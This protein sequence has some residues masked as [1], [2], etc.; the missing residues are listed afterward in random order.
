MIWCSKFNTLP[1]RKHCGSCFDRTL[2]KP[3]AHLGSRGGAK[4]EAK[5]G[6]QTRMGVF[7]HPFVCRATVW[8]RHRLRM[9]TNQISQWGIDQFYF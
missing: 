1:H 9:K 7:R 2:E 4:G 5:G 3:V 8:W 6:G